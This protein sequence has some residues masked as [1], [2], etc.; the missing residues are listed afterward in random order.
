MV[1]EI[2]HGNLFS[3]SY[4]AVME[5]TVKEAFAASGINFVAKNYAMGD[6]PSGKS[7]TVSPMC[8]LVLIK[9]TTSY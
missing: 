4:T 9:N 6:Y 3:Q 1:D 2:G 7:C 8:V 5:D